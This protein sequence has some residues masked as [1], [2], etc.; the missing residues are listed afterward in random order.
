[1]G[2]LPCPQLHLLPQGPGSASWAGRGQDPRD[3]TP[4]IGPRGRAG[5]PVWGLL[6]GAKGH[7]ECPL[8]SWAPPI[9]TKHFI[10]C[11]SHGF[12]SLL[13]PFPGSQAQADPGRRGVLSPALGQGGKPQTPRVAGLGLVALVAP[14]CAAHFVPLPL[15]PAQPGHRARPSWHSCCSGDGAGA[16]IKLMTGWKGCG[17]EVGEAGR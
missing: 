16:A 17:Q 8:H 3:G 11:I 10:S 14:V 4:R 12:H 15:V 13:L 9:I 5:S 7:T 1:M 6:A 2:T